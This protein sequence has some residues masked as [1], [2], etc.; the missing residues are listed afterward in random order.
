MKTVKFYSTNKQLQ[1]KINHYFA[2]VGFP[3]SDESPEI[4]I[5]LEGE[6][7]DFHLKFTLEELK[8]DYFRRFIFKHIKELT[9]VKVDARFAAAPPQELFEVEEKL[10]VMR[11]LLVN[12]KVGTE[13][14]KEYKTSGTATVTSKTAK[15][16][17]I[18]L[19][20]TVKDDD[21][22]KG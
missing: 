7:G 13:L 15:L 16:F 8:D 4:V 6:P 11:E 9:G 17:G 12:E 5:A 21:E 2:E 14:V 3:I 20:K 22:T 19:K 10:K 18:P 1:D